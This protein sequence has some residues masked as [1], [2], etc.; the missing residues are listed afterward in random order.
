MIIPMNRQQFYQ[1]LQSPHDLNEEA[2]IHLQ[3]VV[4]EYPYF[5]AGRM[6]LVKNLN[7]IDHIRF[8]AELKSCAAVISDRRALY[9][10]V[11]QLPPK[12]AL[13]EVIELREE[14]S[15]MQDQKLEGESSKMPTFNYFTVDD[16][17]TIGDGDSFAHISKELQGS[18]DELVNDNK[19]SITLPSA[20]FLDFELNE[21]TGY[22]LEKDV[23]EED[24][25]DKKSFSDWLKIMRS[26]PS[27]TK[28]NNN[29]NLANN[30]W[31]IIDTFINTGREKRSIKSEIQSE[32]VD[33]CSKTKIPQDELM[34]ET[35]ANIFIKQ[36]HFEKALE[37]F[38]KLSLKYPEKIVYFATRKNEIKNLINNQ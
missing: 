13:V 10:L 15:I 5:Q 8:N 30:Q 33:I 28:S 16:D 6:L 12:S 1:Y 19:E 25:D 34:T 9:Y 36:K 21:S 35:L 31:Q 2:L 38:E 22:V 20:D 32:L 26:H 24:F 11:N 3:E 18:K 23:L 4:N 14:P 17:F 7:N 37:I 29:G 27:L